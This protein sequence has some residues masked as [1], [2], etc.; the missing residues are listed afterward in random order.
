[1][2]AWAMCGVD[3]RAST[4]ARLANSAGRHCAGVEIERCRF[5]PDDDDL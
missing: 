4:T 1:M 2:I 5:D 3:M